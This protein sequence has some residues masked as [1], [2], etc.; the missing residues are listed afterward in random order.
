[1]V[2]GTQEYGVEGI[3]VERAVV[4][5]YVSG[6]LWVV[7]T[8]CCRCGDSCAVLGYCGYLLVLFVLSIR[9]GTILKVCTIQSVLLALRSD[10]RLLSS[11][12]A[13]PRYAVRDAFT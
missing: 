12:V 2:E 11:T 4:S 1:M 3:R 7:Q 9:H 8:L 13:G 10:S 5:G 6:G